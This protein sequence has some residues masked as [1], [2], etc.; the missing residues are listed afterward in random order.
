MWENTSVVAFS[1]ICRLTR[2][3]GPQRGVS[4]LPTFVAEVTGRRS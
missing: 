2:Y 3:A 4:F 1:G